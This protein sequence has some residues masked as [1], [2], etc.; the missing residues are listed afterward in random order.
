M[1]ELKPAKLDDAFTEGVLKYVPM[2]D[3]VV[4]AIASKVE[5]NGFPGG[6]IWL[7]G[8]AEFHL[9]RKPE[10]TQITLPL[11]L[12]KDENQVFTVPNHNAQRNEEMG[13]T[14]FSLYVA[15][16]AA[17]HLC[18]VLAE[19]GQ[20]DIAERMRHY[21]E[22]AKAAIYDADLEL[23]EEEKSVISSLIN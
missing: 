4:Y 17:N 15:I 18:W 11:R 7:T 22:D 13:A 2:F 10:N 12:L 9:Y 14:A 1:I 16:A 5:E 8:V 21:Y 19:N 6:H 20:N 23:S 3:S